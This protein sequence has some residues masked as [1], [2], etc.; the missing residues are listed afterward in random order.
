MSKNL[1]NFES[2][3]ILKIKKQNNVMSL[4]HYRDIISKADVQPTSIDSS[5]T[6][7]RYLFEYPS[8][9]SLVGLR[10]THKKL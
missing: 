1:M 4:N 3:V 8:L 7:S 2:K 5:T 6:S 9:D 10:R